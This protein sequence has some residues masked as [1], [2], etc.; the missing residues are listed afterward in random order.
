M[1]DTLQLADIIAPITPPAAPPPYGW[2]ALGVGITLIVVLIA[3]RLW[4]R[5][6]RNRR[7]AL[8]QLKLAAR[9]L[10]Q[11]KLEPRAVVFQAAQAV[12]RAYGIS[13]TCS[14]SPRPL[15]ESAAQT[16][17]TWSI[18]LQALD[19]ARY[20]PH[21]PSASEAMQLLAQAR[22]WIGRAPC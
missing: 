20:A 22:H 7:G 19:Q 4:W 11:Q 17:Q 13:G 3:A 16:A 15:R 1:A 12:N 5:R 10:Q 18:F 8:A 6:N 9:A 2:I 14:K 21:A